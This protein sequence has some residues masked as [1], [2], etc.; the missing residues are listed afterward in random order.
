MGANPRIR[1][2]N[3]VFVPVG[4]KCQKWHTDDDNSK[5]R[6]QHRYFTILIQLNSIDSNCGGTEVWD[7]KM[8]RG[9]MVR[10]L[11][12]LPFFPFILWCLFLSSK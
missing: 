8:K 4:S 9:D 5:K 7:E 6:K 12:L 1:T 11:C 10:L 3:V 2:H